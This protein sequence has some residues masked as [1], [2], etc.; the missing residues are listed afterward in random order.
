MLLIVEIAIFALTVPMLSR[1]R[2][3][4]LRRL[5]A[6]R[7]P[8]P[9]ASMQRALELAT[10]VDRVLQRGR[11]LVR[12]GCMVRGLTR[13]FIL[14]RVGFAV[15]LCFGIG[16]RGD[17]VAGHCWLEAD[18]QPFLEVEDPRLLFVEMYRFPA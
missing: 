5:L 10:L 11:P 8:P 9:A 15:D 14:R 12:P 1:M 4:R 6:P 17:A 18:G 16:G 2:L 7:H 13:Y 3:D